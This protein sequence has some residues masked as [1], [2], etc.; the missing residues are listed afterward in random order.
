MPSEPPTDRFFVSR[1]DRLWELDRRNGVSLA[2]S[3]TFSADQP[4]HFSAAY[5]R[6][7]PVR[8]GDYIGDMR[9]GGSCNFDE[10]YIVPHCNGTHTETVGHITLCGPTIGQ[11][12]H[13]LQGWA[14][15]ISVNPEH[16][17][18]TQEHYLPEL[19]PDDLVISSAACRAAFGS[20][21]QSVAADPSAISM[22]VI[23]TLPNSSEKKSRRYA[24]FDRI[25]FF[26]VEVMEWLNR[27][28]IVHL[29]VDLPSVDRLLDNGRMEN[30]CRFWGVDS[31]TR[32]LTDPQQGTKTITEMIFVPDGVDDGVYWLDLQVPAWEIDAAPSRPVVYPVR[33]CFDLTWKVNS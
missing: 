16:A 1:G 17:A 9:Q 5:A 14:A 26:T 25:P 2:I 3:Q 4:N 11:L 23:R 30:H 32:A 8:V 20:V 18:A 10:V 33:E 22:L 31:L 21:I 28:G 19:C 27:I 6:K 7:E 24:L 13:G 15:V 29:L 12:R